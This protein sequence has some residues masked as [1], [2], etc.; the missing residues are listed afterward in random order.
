MLLMIFTGDKNAKM[1]HEIVTS[2]VYDVK[3]EE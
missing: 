3:N 2:A 1:E